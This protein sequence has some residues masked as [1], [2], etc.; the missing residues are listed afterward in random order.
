MAIDVGA[1]VEATLLEDWG[2][3]ATYKRK[4]SQTFTPGTG[5][6]GRTFTDYPTTAVARPLT[7]EQIARA[8]VP[9]EVKDRRII[10][11]SADLAGMAATPG[12]EDR[13][14][15]GSDTYQVLAWDL[16]GSGG[17]YRIYGRPI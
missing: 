6:V 14:V 13:V 2:V 3:T 5:V 17:V 10:L 7:M 15:I 11:P 12:V 1:D 16:I 8:E 4:A 9:L